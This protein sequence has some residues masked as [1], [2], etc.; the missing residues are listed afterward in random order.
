LLSLTTS[1]ANVHAKIAP[2][3]LA[4]E[5][6]LLSALDARERAQLDHLIDRL[7]TAARHV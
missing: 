1:G 3:A 2:I 4:S 5:A 7:L 6:R